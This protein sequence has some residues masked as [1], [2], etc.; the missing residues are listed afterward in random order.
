MALYESCPRRFFY[1]HVL[2][3][4]GRRA[5]ADFMRLHE[6]VRSVFQAII[7]GQISADDLDAQVGAAC[8][9]QGWPVT[10]MR[11]NSTAWRRP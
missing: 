8:D 6:A 3:I 1:T 4:G 9:A 2:Q 11:L 5:A 10:A 7:G